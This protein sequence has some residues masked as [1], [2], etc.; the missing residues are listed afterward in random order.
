L[1]TNDDEPGE[2]SGWGELSDSGAELRFEDFLTVKLGRLH[3]LV[4]REVA[5]W[6][7]PYGLSL[8]EWRMLAGW[9]GGYSELEMREI[10]RISAMDKAAI[11]RA[12]D[13]LLEKGYAERRVD[14]AHANR[15]I[16]AI[17][18]AGRQVMEQV[19]PAAQR[20]QAWL[21]RQLEPDERRCLDSALM[22]L[23]E[24]LA[25]RPSPRA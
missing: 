7:E 21:L 9:G 19:F 17:T 18:P 24:A 6:L 23:T 14:P 16:I 15:R 11:S 22:R 20:E 4:Q 13:G 3:S 12:V 5:A 8:P 2:D 1:N 25:S 10:A